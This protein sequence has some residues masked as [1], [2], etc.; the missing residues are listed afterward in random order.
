[1]EA[2][3]LVLG[4]TFKEDVADIRNTK[5]LDVIR[6]IQSCNVAV[7]IADPM[8]NP[9]EVKHEYHLDLDDAPAAGAYD[10]VVVA[11]NHEPYRDFT[12]SD[13]RS[14]MRDDDGILVDIKGIFRNQIENLTY[15]SL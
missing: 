9:A 15:W 2:R 11:V 7:D 6:E 10:T 14:F 8:A 13:L 4:L 12:E 3:V 5:V 1:L